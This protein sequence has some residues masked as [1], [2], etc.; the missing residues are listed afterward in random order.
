MIGFI[1]GA[2]VGLFVGVVLGGLSVENKT[3]KQGR[4]DD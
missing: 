2:L 4:K 1:I 3:L